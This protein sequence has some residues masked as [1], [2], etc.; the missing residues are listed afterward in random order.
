VRIACATLGVALAAA[1]PPAVALPALASYAA[2]YD[3]SLIKASQLEGV[4]AASGKMSYA[5]T[6]RCDGF[7]IETDVDV[8]I[9]FSNGLNN[10]VRKRYAGWESKDGRRSTFRMQVTENGEPDD[11]YTGSV[12][13]GA[14]GSGRAVYTG[15]ETVAFDLPAGTILSSTQLRELIDAGRH[16]APFVVQSVMDGAFEDGPYRTTGFIAAER[17]VPPATGAQEAP[18]DAAKLLD[19]PYWPVTLAYFPLNAPAEVP[20][21]ELN[22]QLLDNGVIRSMT[23][24]YGA[25]TLLLRLTG[26]AP[27]DGGCP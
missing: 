23:Q 1:A 16:A 9:A 26:I 13:L 2:T 25:Y 6:D 15:S 10:N 4:R 12:E 22:F 27:R 20:E 18:N 19:G 21:Y 5:L 11:A 24:D 8:D 3:I 7:T 14:D 17:A